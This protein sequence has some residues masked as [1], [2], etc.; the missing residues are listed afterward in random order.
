MLSSPKSHF[1]NYEKA[2]IEYVLQPPKWHLTFLDARGLRSPYFGAFRLWQA[3]GLVAK[4]AR[5]R[6]IWERWATLGLDDRR[7]RLGL[8]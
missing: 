1:L 8:F 3:L 5:Y 2:K 7:A 6:R 4:S